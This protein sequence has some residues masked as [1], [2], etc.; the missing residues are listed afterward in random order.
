MSPD[1]FGLD[2]FERLIYMAFSLALNVKSGFNGACFSLES[3]VIKEFSKAH[4][5]DFLWLYGICKELMNEM[6]K[7]QK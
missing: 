6:I 4:K 7:E 1:E 5:I 3:M 2:E